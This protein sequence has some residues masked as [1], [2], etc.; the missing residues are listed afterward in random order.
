MIMMQD[1]EKEGHIFNM[2]DKEKE[3]H[4]FNMDGTGS[5]GSS[6]PLRAV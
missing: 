2:Q 1:K 6:T 3:G 4:I 5:G